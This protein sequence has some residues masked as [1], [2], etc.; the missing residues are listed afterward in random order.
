MIRDT[1]ILTVES[2]TQSV[3]GF[4]VCLIVT[5]TA[6]HSRTANLSRRSVSMMRLEQLRR[7]ERM[8]ALA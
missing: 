2:R 3:R 7:C 6:C 1:G 4:L 5:G 8:G